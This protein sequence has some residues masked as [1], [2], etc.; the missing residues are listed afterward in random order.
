MNNLRAPEKTIKLHWKYVLSEVAHSWPQAQANRCCMQTLKLP[1][2]MHFK[3][4]ERDLER[5]HSC[6]PT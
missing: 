5:L 6:G 4:Q 3:S 2:D 1:V